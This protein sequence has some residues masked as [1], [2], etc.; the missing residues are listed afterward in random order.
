MAWSSSRHPASLLVAPCIW[1]IDFVAVYVATS[2]ACSSI[3]TQTDSSPAGALGAVMLVTTVGVA[4]SVYAGIANYRQ[5]RREPLD[6]ERSTS[7]FVRKVNM[8]LHALA[9]L[10]MLWVALPTFMLTPCAS[11]ATIQSGTEVACLYANGSS[12]AADTARLPSRS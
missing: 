3:T 9:V 4:F 5:W 12:R 7:T 10:G 1:L 2:I 6:S 8:L 11:S